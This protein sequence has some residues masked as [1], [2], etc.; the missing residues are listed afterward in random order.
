MLTISD[1][2]QDVLSSV[3]S[4]GRI[5]DKENQDEIYGELEY[6]INVR[7]GEGEIS[8]YEFEQ[9][10]SRLIDYIQER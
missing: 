10:S 3:L 2:F 6:E 5:K 9:L 4:G 7:Y 1:L 8:E